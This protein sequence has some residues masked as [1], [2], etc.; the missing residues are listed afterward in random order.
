M[1]VTRVIERLDAFY[2]EMQDMLVV[3][4]SE[5]LAERDVAAIVARLR[6]DGAWS[7]KVNATFERLVAGGKPHGAAFTMLTNGNANV[8]GVVLDHLRAK[9]AGG[10]KSAG[11]EKNGGHN[12]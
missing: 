6:A 10:K 3:T 11:G 9:P 2:I 7:E 8:R 1:D 12:G 4:G 5:E